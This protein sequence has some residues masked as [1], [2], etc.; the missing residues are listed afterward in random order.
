MSEQEQK[1]AQ[2]FANYQKAVEAFVA[3]EQKKIELMKTEQGQLFR[4]MKAAAD[5]Y[6]IQGGGLVFSIERS[7]K[8][9]RAQKDE[10]IH[11]VKQRV[12]QKLQA[13]HQQL[14]DDYNRRK[15]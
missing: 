9:T 11:S 10:F 1:R 12:E 7:E 13:D 4:W 2:A 8:L 6:A 15:A 14:I 3:Y 5:L